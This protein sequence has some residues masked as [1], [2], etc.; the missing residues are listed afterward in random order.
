MF[1]TFFFFVLNNGIYLVFHSSGDDEKWKVISLVMPIHSFPH[2]F[3]G[4]EHI[5]RPIFKYT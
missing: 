5:Y 3:F 1:P 2:I 4:I